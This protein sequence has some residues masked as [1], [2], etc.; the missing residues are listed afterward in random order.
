MYPHDSNDYILGMPFLQGF[1]T[2]FDFDNLKIG[3]AP[4]INSSSF[5]VNQDSFPAWEIAVLVIIGIAL[6]ACIVFT[7]IVIKRKEKSFIRRREISII[8]H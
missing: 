3:L 2:V 6:V 8:G 4:T 5:I 1:Y 7:V